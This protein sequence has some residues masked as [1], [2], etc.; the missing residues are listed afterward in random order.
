MQKKGGI[1]LAD[2]KMLMAYFCKYYPYKDDISKARLNK[3]IYLADWKSAIE[4]GNQLSNIHWLYNNY[5]PYVNEIVNLAQND[6]WFVIYN[7]YNNLGHKKNI[8]YINNEVQDSNIVLSAEDKKYVNFVI[9]STQSLSW[10]N[11]I[12]LV[13]STYPII[14]STKKEYLNLVELAH[15]Y[16]ELKYNNT[17]INNTDLEIHQKEAIKVLENLVKQTVWDKNSKTIKLNNIIFKKYNDYKKYVIP[18]ITNIGMTYAPIQNGEFVFEDDYNKLVDKYFEQ[19][20]KS[21]IEDF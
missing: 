16:N 17:L 10:S 18:Y 6:D 11:F 9:D 19:N 3:M 12:R 14:S 4:S 15:Q 7:T 2:L 21:Y 20:Y 13:Y 8:I 5:G 1:K